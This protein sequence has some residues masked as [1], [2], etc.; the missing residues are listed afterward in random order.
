MSHVFFRQF[1]SP[2]WIQSMVDEKNIYN[3]YKAEKQFSLHGSLS[4]V[5][6]KSNKSD[7]TNIKLDMNGDL[8][9]SII[10]VRELINFFYF[11]RSEPPSVVWLKKYRICPNFVPL[12]FRPNCPEPSVE[13]Y[14]NTYQNSYQKFVQIPHFNLYYWW[15][16]SLFFLTQL[17]SQSDSSGRL[18]NQLCVYGTLLVRSFCGS[19]L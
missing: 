4:L 12:K 2:Q 7:V 5:A 9:P 6:E 17:F 18:G 14:L 1:F 10:M 13:V 19:F 15:A 8:F 11:G 3:T 16:L